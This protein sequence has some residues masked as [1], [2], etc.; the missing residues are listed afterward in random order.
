[1]LCY[2]YGTTTSRF[3]LNSFYFGLF[4]PVA[5]R[6]RSPTIRGEERGQL[7]LGGEERS[8]RD[9]YVRTYVVGT[10]VEAWRCTT[11]SFMWFV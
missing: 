5:F 2:D 11:C 7:R 6:P 1:M 9:T 8:H 10:Q 4:S 3:V